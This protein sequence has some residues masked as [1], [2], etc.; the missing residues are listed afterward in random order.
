MQAREMVEQ[1]P[2]VTL[3]SDAFESGRLIA[4]QRLAGL[5]VT[6]ESGR[7][8]YVLGSSQVVSFMVPTYVQA[9]PALAGV[10]NERLADE[11][12]A[13]LS[14]TPVRDVLPEAPAELAVVDAD[15]TVIELAAA[16]ARTDRP[17]AAVVDGKDLLGVVTASRLLELAFTG[18][19]G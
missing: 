10:I 12:A 7:P 1:Y 2:A 16:M 18:E 15:A 8:R 11:A 4:D 13:R 19:R 17:L 5:V 3:D 14:G 6:D 9:D